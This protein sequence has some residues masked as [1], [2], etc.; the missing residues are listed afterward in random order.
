[1]PD[2]IA[3]GDDAEHPVLVVEDRQSTDVVLSE[4]LG[5]IL[6]RGG[7][8]DRDDLGGHHV[9]D[10]DVLHEAPP[11]VTAIRPDAKAGERR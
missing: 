5:D 6:E 2:Q 8:H 7:R 9:S 3:L 10:L 1:M 11:A 4:Q